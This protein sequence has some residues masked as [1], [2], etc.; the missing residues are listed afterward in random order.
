MTINGPATQGDA[1]SDRLSGFENLIGSAHDDILTGDELATMSLKDLAGADKLDGGDAR[2][3]DGD[4]LSYASSNA[5]V[6][7]D[8]NE[9]DGNFDPGVSAIKTSSGGH[10]AGDNVKFK[11]FENITGSVSQGYPDRGHWRQHA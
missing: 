10:A 5:G 6:T 4:T 2:H 7:I 3:Q 8:L 1:S 9:G 11:S